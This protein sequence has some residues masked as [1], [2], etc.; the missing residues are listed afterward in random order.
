MNR[1]KEI[2]NI[3]TVF[4]VYLYIYDSIL[5]S[6]LVSARS[7]MSMGCSSYS[8]IIVIEYYIL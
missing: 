7:D 3:P 8:S 5:Y 2:S 4:I 6:E 1:K